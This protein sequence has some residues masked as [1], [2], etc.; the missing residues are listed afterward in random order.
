MW[1]AIRMCNLP[2]GGS[3]HLHIQMNLLN[4]RYAVLGQFSINRCWRF[5]KRRKFWCGRLWRP[6]LNSFPRAKGIVNDAVVSLLPHPWIFGFI[7]CQTFVLVYA[8]TPD[9]CG[10]SLHSSAHCTRTP[11]VS[12]SNTLFNG[13][14]ARK[15][16]S[17]A[18]LQTC[19][20]CLRRSADAYTDYEQELSPKP[21][22]K[23]QLDKF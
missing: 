6:A 9:L 15:T 16:V 17:S 18:L 13:G 2:L 3:V 10:V 23:T 21:S 19:R 12:I 8:W 11:E 20:V 5:W 4:K 22:I 7:S 1:G 14:K